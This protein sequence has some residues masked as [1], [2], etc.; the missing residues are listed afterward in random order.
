MD[1]HGWTWW[2]GQG[3]AG[4]VTSGEVRNGDWKC[5]IDA[6]GEV[7]I[8]CTLM[9]GY[10]WGGSYVPCSHLRLLWAGRFIV[11]VH[12][13]WTTSGQVRRFGPRTDRFVEAFKS[14]G[15]VWVCILYRAMC[16]SYFHFN[17]LRCGLGLEMLDCVMSG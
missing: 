17:V 2:L 6:G 11:G 4:L 7:R 16:F 1:L 9:W 13:W 15:P 8:C 10:D 3:Y 5:V 12:A 14:L